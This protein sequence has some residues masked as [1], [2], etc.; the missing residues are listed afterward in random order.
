M[1]V[2]DRGEQNP[3]V[4]VS[5]DRYTGQK[6]RCLDIEHEGN[7]AVGEAVHR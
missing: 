6:R 5:R 4:A 7:V 1:A 3:I 2:F